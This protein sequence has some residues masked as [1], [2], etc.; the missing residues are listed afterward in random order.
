M[1]DRDIHTPPDPLV[2]VAELEQRLG[3]LDAEERELR[4]R[5]ADTKRRAAVQRAASRPPPERQWGV[6]MWG[7]FMFLVGLIASMHFHAVR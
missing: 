4:D 7:V 2:A 1:A 3:E 6:F 5:L